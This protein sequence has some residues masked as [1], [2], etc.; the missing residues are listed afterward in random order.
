VAGALWSALSV[1]DSRYAVAAG[2]M[3]LE[4]T[5]NLPSV[6]QDVHIEQV[7]HY[8]WRSLC[9]SRSTSALVRTGASGG[10]RN[11]GMPSRISMS[12][13]TSP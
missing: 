2:I 1:R 11:T 3:I 13:S 12:A 5:N 7:G 8:W 4:L 6:H 9:R 10:M